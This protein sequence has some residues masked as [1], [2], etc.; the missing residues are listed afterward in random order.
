VPG[1]M[2]GGHQWQVLSAGADHACGVTTVHEGLCWGNNEAGILGL[3][4]TYTPIRIP[5]A[6]VGGVNFASVATSDASTGP[7]G[8]T[9]GLDLD[10]RAYC[11]GSNAYGQ[12]GIGVADTQIRPSPE[13]VEGDHRFSV[14]TASSHATCA[15]KN[16][17]EVYCWGDNSDSG[18]GGNTEETCPGPD[19]GTPAACSTRPIQAAEG[20]AFTMIDAGGSMVCG[21]TDAAALY[22]WGAGY[23]GGG[24]YRESAWPVPVSVGREY[25]S[26]SVG[27]SHSC[28]LATDGL[29]Y[30]WGE[31]GTGAVGD[32]TRTLRVDPVPVGGAEE[33]SG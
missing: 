7:D 11:W 1:P 15:L 25:Q 32:G 10:G 20:M 16:T 27:R 8:H 22:C 31:N 3:G 6:L 14:I 30:C 2:D 4:V 24:P 21:V 5:T 19:G 13:A 23:L 29:A 12:L 17:G 18:L 28:A 26:V 33:I 9:C